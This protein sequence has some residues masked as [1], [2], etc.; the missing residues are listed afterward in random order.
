MRYL[1]DT[2]IF[3]WALM[4]PEKISKKAKESILTADETL[5]SSISFWEIS[6]K[7]SLGKLSL[8]GLS[9]QELPEYAK[10]SGFGILECDALT[11][12]S[13][14]T[15]PKLSHKDPFDRMIIHTAILK[16]LTLVSRD[17]RFDEYAPF[18]L[19]LL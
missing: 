19:K 9:P 17:G 4:D 7:Y 11:M 5:V 14:H 15:L 6:L 16:N 1:I 10:R 12:S 8:N 3:L 18:G 13:F 2:H